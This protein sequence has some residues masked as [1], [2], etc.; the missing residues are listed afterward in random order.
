MIV[1]CWGE[2][3]GER[4]DFSPIMDRP[5]HWEGYISWRPGPLDIEIWAENDRGAKGHIQCQVQIQYFEKSDTVVR[6]V[7]CPYHI[8]LFAEGYRGE[9]PMK[10]VSFDFGE[11]KKV[12]LD[13]RSTNNTPFEITNASWSLL[14]GDEEESHGDC[15]INYI[16]KY[17]YEL[18]SLIQPMRPRCL[19]L[20]KVEYDI[21]DE[22]FIEY[23]KV[24]VGPN[25]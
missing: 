17:E 7:L 12:L 16:R 11:K 15:E 9:L 10:S 19:Y 2:V 3:D 13:I 25:E 21:L 5:G 23:V 6:I 4:I 22:H 18:S 8:R 14:C 1:R 24:R 20:L